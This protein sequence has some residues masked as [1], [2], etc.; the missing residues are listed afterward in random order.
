MLK[1]APLIGGVE[2]EGRVLP[3]LARLGRTGLKIIEKLMG[4]L[5]TVIAVQ[6]L[7]DGL[8]PVLRSLIS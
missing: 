5:V 2:R 3:V 1:A 8:V 6:L 7:I 4:L